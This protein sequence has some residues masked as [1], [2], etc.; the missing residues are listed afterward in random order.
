[1]PKKNEK[2]SRVTTENLIK[3]KNSKD[4]VPVLY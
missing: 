2:K 4:E 1:M 3:D